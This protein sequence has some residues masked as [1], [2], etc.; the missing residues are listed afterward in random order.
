MVG[1][2][3]P[4]VIF[5]KTFCGFDLFEGSVITLLAPHL[6]PWSVVITAREIISLLSPSHS[7][8]T[9]VWKHSVK[10]LRNSEKLEIQKILRT[11]FVTLP[12]TR[13]HIFSQA[14]KYVDCFRFVIYIWFKFPVQ[15][16]SLVTIRDRYWIVM[17]STDT[18]ARSMVMS[19][20]KNIK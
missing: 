17:M 18:G 19:L 7:V 3:L 16:S 20:M 4:P 9:D 11:A 14:A 5:V 1:P 13:P 12:P 15:M 10:W 2:N 8:F 6:N